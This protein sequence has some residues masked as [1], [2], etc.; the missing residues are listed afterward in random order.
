MSIG[1]I[2]SRIFNPDT[3]AGNVMCRI[4]TLLIILAAASCLYFATV[5][6][7]QSSM[8]NIALFI[9]ACFLILQAGSNIDRTHGF[10]AYSGTTQSQTEQQDNQ[11]P[12]HQEHHHQPHKPHHKS[13][14]Q[15]PDEE[16]EP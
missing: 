4:L 16:T 1:N 9:T 11:Q 15:E 14:E 5:T 10:G 8:I 3:T 6:V 12:H 7:F 2:L 13:M